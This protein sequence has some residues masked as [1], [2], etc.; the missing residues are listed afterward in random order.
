M[1]P[2]REVAIVVGSAVAAM[3]GFIVTGSP[4]TTSITRIKDVQDAVASM[5]YFTMA[6][7]LIYFLTKN[8]RDQRVHYQAM[9]A[10][11]A[12][13]NVELRRVQA[14]LT[15]RLAQLAHMEERVQRISQMAALGGLAGPV[16]HEER[17]PLGDIEG[18]SAKLARRVSR[19]GM[20]RHIAV[21]LEEV[22]H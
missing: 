19:P 14:E 3:V 17:K 6:G 8:E 5:V 1:L 16:V 7:I 22:E 12:E 4:L 10:A 20:Q 15:E 18:A 21:L 9:A 2:G 11:M 13:T